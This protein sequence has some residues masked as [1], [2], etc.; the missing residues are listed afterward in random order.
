MTDKQVRVRIAPSPSGYLHVGT[1]R[2]AIFNYLY[3]RHNN[4][5]FLIR[6]EDT[7]V[8]RSDSSLVE[9]ILDA[10]RWLGLEW[11]EEIVYQS[12]RLDIYKKYAQKLVEAGAAYHCFCTREELEAER[13]KARGEKKAPMYSRRCLRMSPEEK[14]K[15]LAAG[16]QPTVRLKIPER[17]LSFD[18]MV[19]GRVSR[20]SNDI[21]DFIVARSDG[22]ATYN[23][24]VVVDD[25]EMGISHV[26]RGN[27]HI[28]NS[29]K[30]IHIYEALGWE[31]PRFGHTPL[32]LRP[33]KKKVSK[34]LGDKDVGEYQGEGLLPQAMF[35]Y[36]CMLGWSPKTEREIYSP[37]E[38]VDLFV[39]ENFNA[40][41][42][43]FN[44]DKLIAFN[45][46]HIALM[47]DH[48][49]AVMVAPLLV[50]AGHTTKY[51]L[52]T[53]WEYLREVVGLLK[54]RVRRVSDFVSLGGY[55]F[56]GD[57]TYDEEAR[58]KQFTPEAGELLGELADAFEQLEKFD[59][60][61]I[62]EALSGLAE[63]REI[64]KAKLIHPTRLAVSGMSVGPGLYD[65]LAAL[66]QLLVV[67][68]M[69]KAADYI[70][71]EITTS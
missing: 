52:E 6:I 17:D 51:W 70:K 61:N 47:S 1:A 9:P 53:R 39:E 65:L 33:D 38:L 35:N 22:S 7:D 18:D 42:A 26:I 5:K 32:I 8:S 30:Q 54:S 2:T 60:D 24:A 64:K 31:V 12:R 19:V 62:A 27:D 63:K 50:E 67:E 15:R 28:T 34:R 14:K 23:L 36:L 56:D 4:G 45:K 41:N 49:L 59:H 25:H 43:V 20:S 46:E 48:D 3:A 29:F 58:I 11:D 71:R 44:E 40:S 69:R 37:Q 66:G 10:L 13:E 21:E 16:E 55:F 57:F 68:R